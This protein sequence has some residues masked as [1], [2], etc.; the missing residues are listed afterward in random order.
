MIDFITMLII[1][2]HVSGQPVNVTVIYDRER[3]CKEAMNISM[4]LYNQ[5]YD[6]YGNEIMMRCVVTDHVSYGKR[7]KAKPFD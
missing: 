3:H 1:S 2:Y 7:P 4:P 6:L 5:L